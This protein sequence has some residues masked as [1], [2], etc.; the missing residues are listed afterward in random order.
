[1]KKA[2]RRSIRE[3][4]PKRTKATYRG[5]M[6]PKQLKAMNPSPS[7]NLEDRE[8]QAVTEDREYKNQLFLVV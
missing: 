3:G 6:R 2:S 8:A 4:L 7:I 5:E 1:M